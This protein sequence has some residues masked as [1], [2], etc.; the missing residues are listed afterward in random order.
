MGDQQAVG[1]DTEQC[2]QP[3]AA[4]VPRPESATPTGTDPT[5]HPPVSEVNMSL[6]ECVPRMASTTACSFRSLHSKHV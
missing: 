6:K 3:P 4:T 1:Q 2:G 5:N